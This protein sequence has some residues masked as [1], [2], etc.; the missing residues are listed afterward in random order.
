MAIMTCEEESL[1]E[2]LEK[3]DGPTKLVGM[4]QH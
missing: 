1:A 2:K 4:A 3:K